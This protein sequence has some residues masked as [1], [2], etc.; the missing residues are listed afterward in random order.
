MAA[1]PRLADPTNHRAALLSGI[2]AL[3][4]ALTDQLASA[5]RFGIPA[6][7]WSDLAVIRAQLL[8]DVLAATEALVV[9]FDHRL[10][11][12]D[13][14]VDRYDALP[15]S[16]TDPEHILIL[17]QAE[18]IVATTPTTPVPPGFKAVVLGR[19]ADFAQVR[20]QFHALHATAATTVNAL[21]G[22]VDALLPLDALDADGFDLTPFEDQ[23][24][25]YAASMAARATAVADAIDARLA[26]AQ[27]ALDA[28]DAAASGPARVAALDEAHRALLGDDARLLPEL[29]LGAAQAAEW[30]NAVLASQSG[31]PFAHLA[32]DHDAPIDDW[33]FGLARVREKLG[34]LEQAL[35]LSDPLGV[36]E[37]EL[38]AIQFPYRP[39][40]PWLGL[41]LPAGTVI[42]SDR[43]LYTA[44][45]DG[46][47]D[48][49]QRQCG[50]LIDEWTEVLPS[51]TQTTGLAFHFDRP[52]SEPPQAWLLVVAPEQTGA[53]DWAD[54]VD[55]LH[56]TLEGARLRAVEPDQLDGTAWA[57]FLPAV[58][59]ATALHPITIAIDYGRVNG[60][61]KLME[62]DDG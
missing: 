36:A 37:P 44:H 59:T 4:D 34:H 10:D 33:L 17:Q 5:A 48:P 42:D 39:G 38:T 28:H 2:D 1:D 55:A 31:A 40:D 29:T 57:R 25:G 60:T 24:V 13:A 49:T 41:E 23:I 52:S 43:L 14:L 15:G 20:S 54:I 19:R 51:E 46:S 26:A 61:L 45:Y 11:D 47:F 7:D 22:A 50:L 12:F 6:T 53:W 56:E 21:L 16:P 32:A 62:A 8:R 35:L 58:V 3:L 18:L 9:R 30:D 27:V